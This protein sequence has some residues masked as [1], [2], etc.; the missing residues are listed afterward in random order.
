MNWDE[1]PLATSFVSPAELT[2][3]VP[4]NRIATPGT[5]FLVVANQ[6]AHSTPTSFPIK[7]SG[8]VITKLDPAAATAGGASFRLTVTGRG[9]QPDDAVHCNGTALPTVVDSSTQM[10]AVVPVE[11]I[12][13]PGGASV[14]IV[15]STS[16]E[17]LA[18]SFL[19]NPADP[20]MTEI[21]PSSATEG[22]GAFTLA[23]KGKGFLPGAVVVWNGQPLETEFVDSGGVTAKVPVELVAT[24]GEASLAIT[25]P[26]GT[27]GTPAAFLVH[28]PVPGLLSV[29]PSSATTGGD[30]LT[31]VVSG[32]G[33]VTGAAIRWDG[34]ALETAFLD[35][36]RLK[37]IVPAS[38]IIGGGAAEVSVSNPDGLTSEVSSFQV[39]EAKPRIAGVAP[40]TLAAGV[41]G[42][43]LA[44]DGSG[45]LPGTILQWDGVP[46]ET[47]FVDPTRLTA[48]VPADRMLNS[49]SARLT[50]VNP[51]EQISEPWP[52]TI[53][54]LRVASFDQE[55]LTAGG[56]DTTLTVFGDGFQAGATVYWN[57]TPL[58]T[59]FSEGALTAA[60]PAR[61][62]DKVG[63]ARIAVA[64]P[65]GL[66]SNTQAFPIVAASVEE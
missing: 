37:A 26:G 39:L 38:W 20:I 5:S 51:H 3:T 53:V 49:G 33:F 44:V 43:V 21:A 29:S 46:L 13:E 47:T 8:P 45:Y 2:V 31:L 50:A 34:V 52:L 30:D 64:I 57:G 54:A 65:G 23:I 61:L 22:T 9:F 1:A 15:R 48:Q 60:V 56:P 58:S 27:E 35:S 42:L 18:V 25:N 11:A 12:T 16:A 17:S 19:V 6:D 59:T 62:I 32:S 63:M 24:A 10:T 66:M 7:A 14:T 55:S 36:T 4:A 40:G 41:S 28:P